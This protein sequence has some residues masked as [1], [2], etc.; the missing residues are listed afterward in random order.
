MG[1]IN[2]RNVQSA[3]SKYANAEGGILSFIAGHGAESSNVA[4]TALESLW[5]KSIA[6][7]YK[8]AFAKH[9]ADKAT[10]AVM[11]SRAKPVWIAGAAGIEVYTKSKSWAGEAQRLQ[12]IL[13]ESG[14]VKVN[15][16]GAHKKVTAGKAV[17]TKAAVASEAREA[18]AKSRRQQVKVYTRE[19]LLEAAFIVTGNSDLAKLL[20][21]ATLSRRDQ[22]SKALRA[23]CAE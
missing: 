16:R 12:A 10:L 3:V 18:K 13:K 21:D 6:P 9:Y 5:T 2:A 19:Q 11:L 23:I 20:V 14:T 17:N 8:S 15:K 1:I 22:L 4:V 7:L